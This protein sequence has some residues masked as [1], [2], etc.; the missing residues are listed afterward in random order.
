MEQAERQA[1]Q[2]YTIPP[3]RRARMLALLAMAWDGQWFLKMCDEYGWEAATRLNAQVRAAFGRIEMR[4]MLRALGKRAA[5]DL[6]DAA[7]ILLTYSQE[8]LAAGFDAEWAVGENQ[9][10]VTITRCAALSG[11]RRAGLERHD[12]ACIACRGLWQVYFEVLLPDEPVEVEVKEQMGHGAPKC[13]VVMTCGGKGR[14]E[15]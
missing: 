1:I 12:Q 2:E 4:R 5:D 14:D 13:R 10:E 3:E 6:R 15:G 7:R 9:A 11:A 8:V